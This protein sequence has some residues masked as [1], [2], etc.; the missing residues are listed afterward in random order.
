MVSF[1]QV[2]QHPTVCYVQYRLAQF[3]AKSTVV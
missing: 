2:E 1:N 3:I